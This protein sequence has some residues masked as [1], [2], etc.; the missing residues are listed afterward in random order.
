M[1]KVNLTQKP[2]QL[3]ITLKD[4]VEKEQLENFNK[5]PILKYTTYYNTRNGKKFP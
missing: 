2:I 5:K 4:K 3:A 1:F